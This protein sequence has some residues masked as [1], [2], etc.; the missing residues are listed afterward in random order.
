[1]TG[2]AGGE[3]CS[4]LPRSAR[5]RQCQDRRPVLHGRRPGTA[6]GQ[7]AAE[8]LRGAVVT[9]A[10]AAA[11]LLPLWLSRARWQIK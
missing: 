9:A 8:H 2:R 4:D 11:L 6:P 3:S 1:V 5:A 10:G 7:P